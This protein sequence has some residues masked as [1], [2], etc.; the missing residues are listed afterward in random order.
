[1]MQIPMVD[2]KKQYASILE[3]MTKALDEVIASSTYI[4]GPSVAL[5]EEAFALFCDAKHCISNGTDARTLALVGLEIR[6]RDEVVTTPHTFG[7]TVEAICRVGA[8]PVLVDIEPERYTIGVERIEAVLSPQ[9]KAI[10]SL[11]IY[12]HPADMIPIQAL[13]EHHGLRVTEDC[14]QAHGAFY[15]GKSVGGL[16][17]VGCFSFY[18]G[19]NIGALGDAGGIVTDDDALADLPQIKLPTESTSR[20]VYHLFVVKTDSRDAQQEALARAGI[21]S[22]VYYPFFLHLTPAYSDLGY[23]VCDLL[24]TRWPAEKSSSSP[25][26]LSYRTTR[27]TRRGRARQPGSASQPECG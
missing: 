19:K 2:L 1:M 17:D 24:S 27:S 4:F 12:G 7:A 15:E 26:S 18:P 3:E 20:Y 10:L 25:C 13:A 9:T 6:P 11:H 21:T 14:A 22:S 5:F 23:G 8:R 16:G